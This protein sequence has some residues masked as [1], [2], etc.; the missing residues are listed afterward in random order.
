VTYDVERSF[1]WLKKIADAHPTGVA[2]LKLTS[3]NQLNNE[4]ITSVTDKTTT[5][6]DTRINIMYEFDSQYVIFVTI[7][8]ITGEVEKVFKISKG[9]D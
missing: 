4:V 5:S 1:K 3:Q 7:E 8:Y 6:R 9:V 2:A